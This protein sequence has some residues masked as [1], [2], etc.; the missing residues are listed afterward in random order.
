M[1]WAPSDDDNDESMPF[2]SIA[3]DV[4]Q[5]S[6][7][8]RV[9]THQSSTHCANAR[10]NVQELHAEGNGEEYYSA[11]EGEPTG[12]ASSRVAMKQMNNHPVTSSSTEVVMEVLYGIMEH[13]ENFKWLID[14]VNQARVAKLVEYHLREQTNGD[15]SIQAFEDEHFLNEL[16]AQVDELIHENLKIKTENVRLMGKGSQS[17]AVNKS[18]EELKRRLALSEEAVSMQ[19]GYRREAEVVFQSELEMKSKLVSSLQHDLE[20]KDSQIAKLLENGTELPGSDNVAPGS[21]VARLKSTVMEKDR[22]ICR[23]NFQL[24][25]KQKL[26]DEIAKK[27]VQQLETTTTASDETVAAL[28]KHLHL[29]MD[30]FLFKSVSEKQEL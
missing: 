20:E 23:L 9:V 13:N 7:V 21:E 16:R 29:D 5:Q 19:E 15:T 4:E 17:A 26:V 22:E 2:R 10:L 24:S 18:I 11:E 28:A 3:D 14:P 8:S 25:T 12:E 27:V 6:P 1:D 30:M